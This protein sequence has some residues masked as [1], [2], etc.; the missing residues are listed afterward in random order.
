MSSTTD[1]RLDRIAGQLTPQQAVL[2]WM[3]E[4]HEYGTIR[5]YL[6]ALRDAPDTTYPMTRLPERVVQAVRTRMKGT[7]PEVVRRAAGTAVR[8][9]AFLFSLQ[10]QVT[11]QLWGEWRAMSFQLASVGR[12]LSRPFPEEHPSEQEL[13][14][15][16][17]PARRMLQEYL[18]WDTAIAMIAARYYAGASPLFPGDAEQLRAALHL[19]EQVVSLFNDHL[20]SLAWE[21][22]TGK[23]GKRRTLPPLSVEPLD[24]GALREASRPGGIELARQLVV[25]AQVEAAEFLGEHQEARDLVRAHLWPERG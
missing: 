2:L 24:L 18:A 6:D 8:Q 5:A 22:R 19:A 10:L 20:D 15:S 14:E 21:R 12:R 11:T 16:R 7:R 13:A 4:A 1:R 3:Q 9:V 17:E 25:M 23:T